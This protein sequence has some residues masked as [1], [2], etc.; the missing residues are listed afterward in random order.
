MS[1]G[2]SALLAGMPPGPSNSV[3]MATIWL[4]AARQGN[5]AWVDE[6][7]KRQISCHYL[8]RDTAILKN[9]ALFGYLSMAFFEKPAWCRAN[10]LLC[11]RARE[12]NT[13][14]SI[15]VLDDAVSNS[16]NIFF[17][18]CITFHDLLRWQALGKAHSL[19]SWGK[20]H[21][22]ALFAALCDSVVALWIHS[23]VVPGYAR[24][25]R[26]LRPLV[27]LTCSHTVRQ[28]VTH[29]VMSVPGFFSVWLTMAF[30]IFI[31]MWVSL[32]VFAENPLGGVDG[33]GFQSWPQAAY[34]LW[35]A[36]TTANFPNVMI[37]G[38]NQN[39]WVFGFFCFYM[40]IQLFLLENML[41]AV[42]YDAYKSSL[43]TSLSNFHQKRLNSIKHAYFHLKD[44]AGLVRIQTWLVFFKSYCDPGDQIATLEEAR[45][46]RVILRRTRHMFEALNLW[47]NVKAKRGLD[48]DEF[49]L[50]CE[51]LC[52]TSFQML[53]RRRRS[54]GPVMLR[55]GPWSVSWDLFVDLFVLLE[56]IVAC[57]QTVSFTYD[58]DDSSLQPSSWYFIVLSLFSVLFAF[59]VSW[60]IWSE[61]TK[62][63]WMSRPF[64]NRFEFFTVYTLFFGSFLSFFIEQGS[65]ALRGLVLLR[66]ARIDRLIARM[67]MMK[68]FGNVMTSLSQAYLQIALL[69]AMFF[70]AYAAVGVELF[71]GLIDTDNILLTGSQYVSANYWSLSWND[72]PSSMVA[73]FALM[74]ANNW[75]ILSD[76]IMRVSSNWAIV[77]FVSFF[78]FTHHIVLNILV[79]LILDVS[80]I[81]DVEVTEDEKVGSLSG[82][83]GSNQRTPHEHV[84]RAEQFSQARL[85][86]GILNNREDARVSQVRG[87]VSATPL[88][89]IEFSWTD[90]T[91]DRSP[92]NSREV[93]GE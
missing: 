41:L 42:V 12:S 65:F 4:N 82:S 86:G 56:L 47:D 10:P 33:Q 29:V 31:S 35:I 32:V 68:K 24:L 8:W 51:V 78:V 34:S 84:V 5:D 20:L 92:R 37:P 91:G 64:Q 6:C 62:D 43:Q 22:V 79:A 93:Q 15:S 2:S 49:V 38:Y 18:L 70:Y 88:T 48:N 76:A 14:M 40:L 39:R 16:L 11:K 30:F 1:D 23:G 9:L 25:S 73:L 7:G 36:Y 52:D 72:F 59:D 83:L 85:L 27:L 80:A 74:I 77:Y 75:F 17:L 66:M 46:D 81:F 3:E 60:R 87:R 26:L 54:R 28:T 90:P 50:V 69:L 61:G 63:F 89:S 58:F 57:A 19:N 71:G 55:F 53:Q 67:G 13:M 44:D 45:A 21:A